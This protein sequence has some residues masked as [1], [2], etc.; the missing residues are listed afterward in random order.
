MNHRDLRLSR[1]EI[2]DS[3]L[4]PCSSGSTWEGSK[5]RSLDRWLLQDFPGFERITAVK[6]MCLRKWVGAV[7]LYSIVDNRNSRGCPCCYCAR[8]EKRPDRTQ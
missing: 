3:H 5:I 2:S 4:C 1:K 6:V 7:A 8:P